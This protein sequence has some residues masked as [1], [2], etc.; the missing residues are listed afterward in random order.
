MP[1]RRTAPSTRTGTG[2]RRNLFHHQ[3]SR[4]PTTSSTSTSAETLRLSNELD[5]TSSDSSDI[6]IRDSN[7][8]FEIGDPPMQSFDEQEVVAAH[9]EGLEDKERQR[10]SDAVKHHRDRNRAPSEP[11]ELL[12]AVKNSLRAKV[13]RLAE[14]N[15]MYEP[16]EEAPVR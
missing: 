3:L 14:D 1:E 13:A 7:G 9:D 5:R 16:E 12:E 10:I 6:V 15:W 2:V 8:E 11:A 4:R